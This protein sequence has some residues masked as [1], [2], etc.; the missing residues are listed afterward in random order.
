MSRVEDRGKNKTKPI[1]KPLSG[2]GTHLGHGAHFMH[3]ADELA[4]GLIEQEQLEMQLVQPLTQLQLL[5]GGGG[6]GTREGETAV[7]AQP[8]KL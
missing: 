3:L 7:K 1:R 4:I 6:E 2:S 5:R 8:T